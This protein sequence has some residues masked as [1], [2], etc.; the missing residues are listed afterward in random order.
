MTFGAK[1]AV[2]TGAKSCAGINLL[3]SH[4]DSLNVALKI[5]IMPCKIKTRKQQKNHNMWTSN[6]G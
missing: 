3:D 4:S 1:Q 6:R 2:A 5:T